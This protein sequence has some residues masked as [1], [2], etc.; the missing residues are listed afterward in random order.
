MTDEDWSASFAKSLTV[1]LNGAGIPSRGPRGERIT[2]DSFLM[3]FNAHHESVSFKLPPRRWGRA[4]V[5]VLDTGRDDPFA[6][7][8]ETFAAESGWAVEPRSLVLLR[9]VES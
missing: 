8:A 3:L 1:Y 7:G 4:W 5:G 9:R 6:G 2:D